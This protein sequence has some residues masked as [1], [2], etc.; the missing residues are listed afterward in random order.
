MQV[1]RSKMFTSTPAFRYQIH[2]NCMCVHQLLEPSAQHGIEL[3][4]CGH[5]REEARLRNRGG[6]VSLLHQRQPIGELNALLYSTS[7]NISIHY[8]TQNRC[9]TCSTKHMTAS[10]AP[11]LL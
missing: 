6:C 1:Q 2:G 4:F 11:L 10:P 5:A 9:K 8:Y 7:K 3:V